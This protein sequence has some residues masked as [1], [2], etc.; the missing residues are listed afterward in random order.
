MP[1]TQT[2]K[3]S[4]DYKRDRVRASKRERE[5]GWGGG[6]GGGGAGG[7]RIKQLSRSNKILGK[8]M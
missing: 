7:E 3:A 1:E 6:L 5:K 4:E 2:S 8:P